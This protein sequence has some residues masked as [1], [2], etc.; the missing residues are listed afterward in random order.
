MNQQS[1]DGDDVYRR[2]FYFVLVS[3]LALLMAP[4]ILIYALLS[5]QIEE[6]RLSSLLAM[7]ALLWMMMLACAV[8]LLIDYMRYQIRLTTDSIEIQGWRTTKSMA[9]AELAQL[10]EEPV[11][12]VLKDTN[13]KKRL[14]I[15]TVL[16]NMSALRKR[17]ET[18][19]SQNASEG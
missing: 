13:G 18:V 6:T 11:K 19:C 14:G 8:P 9:L 10:A 12:L 15:S 17:L 1:T 5:G 7:L 4:A 16:K 3:I 2:P